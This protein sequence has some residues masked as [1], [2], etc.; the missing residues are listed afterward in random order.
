MQLF[1]STVRYD[2]TLENG[3]IKT[4][5]EQYLIDAMSFTEAEARTI[6]TLTPYISGDF[7]IPQITRPRIS[8]LVLAADSGC[9]RYYKVK[10]AFITIDE[11]TAVEKKTNCFILVQASNFKNA[12]LRFDKHMQGSLA[13]YEILSIAETPIMDYFPNLINDAEE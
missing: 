9:D 3:L 10:I 5:S 8:E 1:I 13:D 7:I 11:N 12:C 2:K 4:V 6:E